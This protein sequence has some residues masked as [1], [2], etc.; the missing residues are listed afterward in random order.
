MVDDNWLLTGKVHD[1]WKQKG[2]PYYQ[3]ERGGKKKNK[4][5]YFIKKRYAD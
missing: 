3:K 5:I 2:F 4:L 1:S